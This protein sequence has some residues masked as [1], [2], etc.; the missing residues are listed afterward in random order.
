VELSAEA[1]AGIDGFRDLNHKDRAAVARHGTVEQHP[2]NH[3]ILSHRDQG[4]DVFMIISGQVRATHYSRNGKEVTFRELGAGELFG[5]LSAIDGK[6]RSAHVVTL[7]DSTIGRMSAE[8]FWTVLRGHPDFA[9]LMLEKLTSQVRLLS[10]RVVEFS[11]LGVKNRIHTEL[12]RLAREQEPS[13]NRADISPVP[14]H[15]YIASRVSTH[16]E[17]VTR[18]LNG[19]I[20][21]GLLEKKKRT[22]TVTD[23]LRLTKMVEDVSN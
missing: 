4:S 9:E 15:A 23:L 19:L 7:A 1:L 5:E 22:L 21:S 8:V 2:N 12:L 20:Q 3:L 16:R 17:A 6:P 14:T 10:D 11:T 18:E 13:D